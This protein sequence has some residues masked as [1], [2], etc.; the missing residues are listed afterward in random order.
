MEWSEFLIHLF[1]AEIINYS[2]CT[3]LLHLGNAANPSGLRGT[4]PL[5]RVCVS[6][7]IQWCNP[8]CKC[9]VTFSS[10]HPKPLYFPAHSPL[11]PFPC[12]TAP[13]LLPAHFQLQ[14][15]ISKAAH[16][17]VPCSSPTAQNDTMQYWSRSCCRAAATGMEQ[18]KSAR[19]P[20]KWEEN[21]LVCNAKGLLQH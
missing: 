9:R 16:L 8:L 13:R 4:P 17:E 14:P 15:R 19:V 3:A 5:A 7:Q 20:Q 21:E 12:P 10:C 2:L 18:S 1:L 11:S 6:L